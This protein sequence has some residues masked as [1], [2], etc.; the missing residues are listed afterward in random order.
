MENIKK[1]EEEFLIKL[2]EKLLDK[3]YE[4]N[5]NFTYQIAQEIGSIFI[6]DLMKHFSE[7]NE[8]DIKSIINDNILLIKIETEKEITL[9]DIILTTIRN[10]EILTINNILISIKNM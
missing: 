7:L 2:K 1:I 8:F 9:V 4:I 6:L 5:S 3:K 10:H